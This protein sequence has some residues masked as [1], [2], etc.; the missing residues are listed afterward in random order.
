MATLLIVTQGRP[1]EAA[2]PTNDVVDSFGSL[3]L[4]ASGHTNRSMDVASEWVPEH[5][6]KR[7]NAMALR[8]LSGQGSHRPKSVL[9]TATI[10]SPPTEPNLNKN[11]SIG[12]SSDLGSR[13]TSHSRTY[14]A[15]DSNGNVHVRGARQ[16]RSQTGSQASARRI[17]DKTSVP[18]SNG[19]AKPV[20]SNK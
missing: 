15:I 13:T 1:G 19:F 7:E 16:M 10:S 18:S 20:S 14:N 5:L 2:R 9:S 12:E 3:S 11:P 6:M 8:N 17:S 4:S